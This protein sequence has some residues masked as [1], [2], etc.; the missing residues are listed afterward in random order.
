MSGA[1]GALG[2]ENA[3]KALEGLKQGDNENEQN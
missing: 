2:D 1:I 3:K